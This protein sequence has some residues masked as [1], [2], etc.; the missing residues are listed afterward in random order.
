MIIGAAVAIPTA[1]QAAPQDL[2]LTVKNGITNEGGKEFPI[3][4]RV[5]DMQEGFFI[6]DVRVAIDTT[7][8]TSVTALATIAPGAT[9]KCT[10]A[11]TITTCDLGS[12]GS[13]DDDAQPT[14]MVTAKPG[15]APGT[16]GKLKVTLTAKG[17]E[18]LVVTP[19]V[20]VA[21]Q[22]D[23]AISDAPETV[24]AKPGELV[25]LGV[26]ITNRGT[27]AIP[28][29]AL[30]IAGGDPLTRR[31]SFDNCYH[32]N[33]DFETFCRFETTLE[34]GKTYVV[35]GTVLGVRKDA[36]PGQ[37]SYGAAVWTLDDIDHLGIM[38]DYPHD[39]GAPLKLVELPGV[40]AAARVPASDPDSSDDLAKG[41]VTILAGPS[42]T[43][44]S[45]AP[46]ATP[47][48]TPTTTPPVAGGDT[49][50]EGGGGT[51]PITGSPIG[52]IATIGVS[53]L[54]IGILGLV[55][56]R[57]RARFTA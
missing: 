33:D 25:P 6:E 39:S 4:L 30:R 20:T 51:L 54:L 40:A 5:P 11:A 56:T 18:P 52:L 8:I 35:D 41:K 29:V 31:S 1:A 7:D 2:T 26:R 57:R 14:M 34:P 49:G 43:P 24:E 36:K 46:T 28:G 55:A 37:D 45:P 23:L 50:G 48:A 21:E 22:V 16:T 42:P 53:A 13:A 12:I 32:L 10:T 15:A 19:T 9:P 17:I 38:S 47:T 3:Y 44:S 27:N